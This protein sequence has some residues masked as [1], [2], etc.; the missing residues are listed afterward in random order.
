MTIIDLLKKAEEIG[1]A[2][3]KREIRNRDCL[4]ALRRQ[5]QEAEGEAVSS[6]EK[7]YQR[8]LKDERVPHAI[9]LNNGHL[10]IGVLYSNMHHGGREEYFLKRDKSRRF[11]YY[12]GRDGRGSLL[13]RE[14][15]NEFL[16]NGTIFDQPERESAVGKRVGY[17]DAFERRLQ[18][19]LQKGSHN[20]DAVTSDFNTKREKIQAEISS[21]GEICLRHD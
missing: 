17:Q 1:L 15:A 6:A 4:A 16:K 2:L 10:G 8:I 18:E 19:A 14:L 13:C 21:L 9:D 12:T 7:F 20:L 11:I 3:K 5:E